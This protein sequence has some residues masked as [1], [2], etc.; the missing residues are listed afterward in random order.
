MNTGYQNETD[1]ERGE[2]YSSG[3]AKGAYRNDTAD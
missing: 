2:D 3:D 1:E